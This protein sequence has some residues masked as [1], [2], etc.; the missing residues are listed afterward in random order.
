MRKGIAIA[1]CFALWTLV[2]SHARAQQSGGLKIMEPETEGLCKDESNDE[3]AGQSWQKQMAKLQEMAAILKRMA[4][5]QRKL[6]EGI[7]P[8]EGKEIRAELAR[9]TEKTDRMLSDL[10]GMMR[11]PKKDP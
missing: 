7:N 4:A 8:A 2:A 10:Q 6:A 1:L 3:L 9:M 5:I 11:G